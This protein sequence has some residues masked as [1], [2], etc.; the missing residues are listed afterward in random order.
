MKNMYTGKLNGLIGKEIVKNVAVYDG[1]NGKKVFSAIWTVI[2]A[3]P[4]YV[5]ATRKTESG[6]VIKE[7][8]NVGDLRVM[9]VL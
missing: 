3:Y 7:C 8:F 4:N 5:I 9:G 6:H 1:F 2:E